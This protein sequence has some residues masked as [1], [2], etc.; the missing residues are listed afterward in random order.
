MK[1]PLG[2]PKITRRREVDEALPEKQ[3]DIGCNASVAKSL[4]II[5]E[6]TQLTLK[7]QT[8]RQSCTKSI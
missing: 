1:R 4:V 6:A 2:R 8:R 3:E 5:E 7:I